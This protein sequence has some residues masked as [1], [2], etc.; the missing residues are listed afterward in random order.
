MPVSKKILSIS[1]FNKSLL[2]FLKYGLFFSVPLIIAY[3]ILEIVALSLPLSYKVIG[4]YLQSNSQKIEMMALGSSQVKCGF[5]P[6]FSNKTAINLASTSQH[7]K[8][9]FLILQ[10]TIDRLSNLKYVLF[11]VSY[12]H[13]ELPYHENDYWKNTIYLK[14]YNVN[15]FERATYFKDKLLYL[16]NARFF[17]AK[18]RDY[19]ICKD[20]KSQFNKFGFDTNKYYGS[21]NTLNYDTLKIARNK[22]KI[23]THENLAIFKNNTSYLFEMLDYMQNKNLKVILC[24][25]PLYKTY[26]KERNPNIVHR[27]DSVLKIIKRKYNNVV[28]LN[29]ETDTLNFTVNDFLNE[30]HLNPDGAKKFTALI[31][32]KLDSLN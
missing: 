21:F 6:A 17:S 18:I 26:L 30:N 32:R 29:E 23:R 11:E 24:T 2:H 9:D 4:N 31:N 20:D 5:N 16:S 13:L 7:H 25:L 12:M 22:F 1:N 15:A 14:Y 28:L 3:C 10:G 19:Y 27:R 8:E